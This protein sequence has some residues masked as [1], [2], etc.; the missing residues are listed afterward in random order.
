MEASDSEG[1]FSATSLLAQELE[2]EKAK[3]KEER[4]LWVISLII[5]LDLFFLKDCSNWS[6]PLII[7]VFEVAIIFVLS[8][9]WSVKRIDLLFEM[10]HQLLQRKK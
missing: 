7:G 2:E 4:L 1:E 10:V 6:L 8:Q 5:L 3:R 9:K